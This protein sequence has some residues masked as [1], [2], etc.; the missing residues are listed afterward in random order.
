MITSGKRPSNKTR[1][2]A[3]DSPDNKSLW[4]DQSANNGRPIADT[5]SS[6]P[7]VKDCY[8]RYCLNPRVSYPGPPCEGVKR[9]VFRSYITFFL[10]TEQHLSPCK[11]H[12]LIG[13]E[14]I[15][16][17]FTTFPCTFPIL[18]FDRAP[19][20]LHRYTQENHSFSFF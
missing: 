3:T 6:W 8:S 17:V 9:V 4:Q 19:W 13:S 5:H 1:M 7:S 16:T 11:P 20:L 15:T 12:L 14:V 2:T 10:S 18:S